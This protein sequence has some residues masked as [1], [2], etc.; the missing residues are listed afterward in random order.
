[1]KFNTARFGEL[2]VPEEQLVYFPQ[3]LPGFENLRQFT[4]INSSE[5]L[6]FSFMQSVEDG[7]VTF[8][9]ADPFLF[10]P[11]YS[12]ALS[13]SVKEE[14]QLESEGDVQIKAIITIRESLDSATINLQSP[15]V[16]NTRTRVA[17]QVIL[18]ETAYQSKHPLIRQQED[19]TGREG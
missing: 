8:I 10:Y 1:M 11:E 9:T 18:H 5:E 2:E 4:W 16:V 6:P 7:N 13:D 12:F 14:L 17:K 3:G 15:I 19:M